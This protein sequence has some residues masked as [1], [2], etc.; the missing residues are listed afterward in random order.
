M[1]KYSTFGWRILASF[2]DG[3][4]MVPLVA[5]FMVIEFEVATWAYWFA[6]LGLSLLGNTYNIFLH[7]RYGQTL[8]KM[9]VGVK[10]VDHETEES[11]TFS[12]A[13][14]RDLPNIAF[15]VLSSVAIFYLLITG[16]DPQAEAYRI[17]ETYPTYGLFIFTMINVF[18]C[19]TNIQN[20]AVHD[21]LAGTV[22]IRPEIG[23]VVANDPPEPDEYD[24]F[25]EDRTEK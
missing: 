5:P 7:W 24:E 15:Q 4:V 16:I 9:A 6:G 2:V 21:M 8:G 14:L 10:V 13:V 23:E 22:V 20:R 17:A 25:H 19:I 12:Q 18:V 1:N 3:I 11:I